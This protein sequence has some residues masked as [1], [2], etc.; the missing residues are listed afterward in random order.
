MEVRKYIIMKTLKL[1][2]IPYFLVLFVAMIIISILM[3]LGI[4]YIDFYVLLSFF[5]I[6]L[7]PWF[8]ALPFYGAYCFIKDFKK[9]SYLK[10]YF[11]AKIYKNE[12]IS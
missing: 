9:T 12:K 10:Q 5:K 3:S 4:Q 2:A 11:V 6:I 7:Y 8:G 1:F